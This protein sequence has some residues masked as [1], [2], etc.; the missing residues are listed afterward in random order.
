MIPTLV[1]TLTFVVLLALGR[2][3]VP[4]LSDW[5]IC[6]RWSLAAMFLVTASAHFNSLRADLVRM[7]PSFVPWPELA[8]T[9]TGVLE[10][11]GA[12]GLVIPATARA[13]SIGLTLLLVA[14]FPA[15]VHAALADLELGGRPA[16]PLVLRTLMQLL[17]LV[18]VIIA[19]YA[20]PRW[21]P[22]V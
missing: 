20:S 5:V 12:L 15:N 3:S 6:L 2:L 11:L 19:G 14:M 1:L 22:P 4:A 9:L 21:T 10:V 7:V 8:V 13:A 18:A 16:T 17:F